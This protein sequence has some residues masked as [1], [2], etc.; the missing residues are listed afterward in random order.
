MALKVLV[1][2]D[3]G[4]VRQ[5][6]VSM[7]MDLGCEVVAEARTG[8]EA[9][10]RAKLAKPDLIFMDMVLPEKNGAEAAIE[11]LEARPQCRIIAMS[12][13]TEEI[14][15]ARANQAGCIRFLEKP[16]RVQDVQSLLETLDGYRAP[17]RESVG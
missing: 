9:I 3:A 6:L 1:V 8:T 4:F 2:D 15:R 10:E 14:V 13:A 11:I 5:I 17:S 7:L 12:T 16:F